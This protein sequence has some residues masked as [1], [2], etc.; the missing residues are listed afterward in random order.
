VG[1]LKSGPD[2]FQKHL[3]GG[4]TI[5]RTYRLDDYSGVTKGWAVVE[6]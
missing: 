2:Y 5:D 3:L 6:V 1:G 4:C